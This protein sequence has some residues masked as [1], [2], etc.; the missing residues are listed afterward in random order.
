VLVVDVVGVRED[1][2]LL[3]VRTLVAGKVPDVVVDPTLT[4]P[5]LTTQRYT[6]VTSLAFEQAGDDACRRQDQTLLQQGSN[7]LGSQTPT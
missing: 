2:V 3:V 5:A 4:C 6:S 7:V 1:V